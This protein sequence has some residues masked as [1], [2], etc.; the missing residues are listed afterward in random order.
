MR[1]AGSPGRVQR[2]DKSHSGPCIQSL[3]SLHQRFIRAEAAATPNREQHMSKFLSIAVALALFAPVAFATL[4]QA[5]LIV[6]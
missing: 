1:I 4:N 6:A 2:R 5:A 3:G